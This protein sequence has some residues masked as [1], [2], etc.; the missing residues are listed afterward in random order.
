MPFFQT[1]RFGEE[2]TQIDIDGLPINQLLRI[3]DNAYIGVGSLFQQ[4]QNEAAIFELDRDGTISNR[5]PLN[6]FQN[7]SV[8]Q[9]KRFELPVRGYR[10]FWPWS[11][12]Q[13]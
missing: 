4:G 8:T 9:L 3:S 2:N 6:K 1:D 12:K 7:I 13:K 11:S 10:L 5:E